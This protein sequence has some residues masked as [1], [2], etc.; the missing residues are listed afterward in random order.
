M[1]AI[2]IILAGGSGMRLGSNIPKQYL[3]VKDK[4]IIEYT[5]E[6]FQNHKEIDE[7]AVV[8]HSNYIELLEESVASNRYTKVKK[9]L[10]GGSERYESSVN[11]IK[12]YDDGEEKIMLFHD[13][14]RPLV[15]AQMI[16]DSIKKLNAYNAVGVGVLTTDTIWEVEDNTIKNIP[17]RNGFYRAQTPQSF[18][19]SIIKKAYDLALCQETIVAS[20]DCGI[21]KR[22]LPQEEIGLVNGDVTNI[23]ITQKEDLLLLEN[24]ISE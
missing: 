24:L 8:G 3:K 14:V 4:M 22:Y 20:D 15:S 19:F 6:V 17:D 5:I 21:V 12:A 10:C 11:G 23:K 16:S 9:I 13:A 7:I 2:A 1:K 18:K